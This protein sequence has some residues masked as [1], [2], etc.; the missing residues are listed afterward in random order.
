MGEGINDAT[1]RV[2]PETQAARDLAA[3]QLR[4][5]YDSNPAYENPELA[6][7]EG[8]VHKVAG[9]RPRLQNVAYSPSEMPAGLVLDSQLQA[10]AASQ[11]RSVADILAGPPIGAAGA[12]TSS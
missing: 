8:A 10:N 7:I 6:S 2:S 3:V 1:K 4:A 11:K 5:Q 9:G 12:S